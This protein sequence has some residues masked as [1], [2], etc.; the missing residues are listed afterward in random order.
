MV[1]LEGEFQGLQLLHFVLR[2]CSFL[3]TGV[4]N[5]IFKKMQCDK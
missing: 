1:C 3:S 2:E 4:V 5:V